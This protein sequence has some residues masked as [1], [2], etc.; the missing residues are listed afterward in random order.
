M[1]NRIWSIDDLNE[2]HRLREAGLSW[3]VIGRRFGVKGGTVASTYKQR[4][5]NHGHAVGP[6]RHVTAQDVIAADQM[7]NEGMD[8]PQIADKLNVRLATLK[9]WYTSRDAIERVYKQREPE[10]VL[11]C[12]DCHRWEYTGRMIWPRGKIGVCD[13]DGAVMGRC[14]KCRY[15]G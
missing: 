10:P 6:R 9:K 14:D 4:Y 11:L 12:G 13:R 2:V 1:S 15:E 8:W 7:I 3:P 5:L